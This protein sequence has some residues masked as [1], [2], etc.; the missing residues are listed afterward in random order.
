LSVAKTRIDFQFG[1]LRE[2]LRRQTR[3]VALL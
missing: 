3:P 2:W 1:C